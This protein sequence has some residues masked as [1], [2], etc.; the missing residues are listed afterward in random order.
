MLEGAIQGAKLGVS[1]T[2]PILDYEP[3]N[4]VCT[5]NPG[6]ITDIR[7]K[8]VALFKADNDKKINTAIESFFSWDKIIEQHITCYEKIINGVD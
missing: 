8:L 2:L 6:A 3:L 5:F 1:N 7:K 4:G